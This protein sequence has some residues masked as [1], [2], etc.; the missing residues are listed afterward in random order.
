MVTNADHSVSFRNDHGWHMT[1]HGNNSG[2]ELWTDRNKIGDWEKFD[3][4]PQS[5][6]FALRSHMNRKFVSVAPG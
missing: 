4:V 3:L 6:Y 5:G 1:A 2:D